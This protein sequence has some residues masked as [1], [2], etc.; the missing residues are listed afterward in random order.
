MIVDIHSHFHSKYLA[1]K[2]GKYGPF[3][4]RYPDG[5]E[6]YRIGS[7]ELGFFVERPYVDVPPETLIRKMDE[8]GI[9]M[10]I[11]SPNPLFLLH[12]SDSETCIGFSRAQ[13]ELIAR[14]VSHN[15]K[16]FAGMGTLPL[17]SMDDATSELHHMI[18]D[19][20]LVGAIINP[21]VSCPPATS[22]FQGRGMDS[23]LWDPL[24]ETA[25]DLNIPLFIHP[26]FVETPMFEKY[27]LSWNLGFIMEETIAVP[28]IIFGGVLERFP[29]LKLVIAHAGGGIP[30]QI[31]RMTL[32]SQIL[33]NARTKIT[34]SF[35]EYFK[36]LYFDGCLPG[37]NWGPAALKYLIS[38]VGSDHVLMGSDFPGPFT[39]NNE[40]DIVRIANSI[41]SLTQEEKNKILGGN[42]LEVFRLNQ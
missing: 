30:F 12:W 4:G 9:D 1:G 31:G 17:Q 36:K 32:A 18:K 41:N 2:A 10:L 13:N 37:I 24:Y 33:P 42:A 25:I 34:K 22:R 26:T 28:T 40:D 38:I 15:P 23:E 3:F 19:L 6:F 29:K 16:R 8:R 39:A 35:H 11:L 20:E 27:D 21:D 14:T 7:K 5:S